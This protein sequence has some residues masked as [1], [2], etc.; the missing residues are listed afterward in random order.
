M[1]GGL[2][3]Y[4]YAN[5]DPVNFRDPS[6]LSAS[7]GACVENGV[8]LSVFECE[9]AI[10]LLGSEGWLCEPWP[11]CA[12]G[13]VKEPLF[14]PLEILGFGGI[15][16]GIGKASL[17]TLTRD[18]V[19]FGLR[20]SSIGAAARRA[21]I[22][23]DEFVDDVVLGS[24]SVAGGTARFTANVAVEKNSLFLRGL[25]IEGDGTLRELTDFAR[26]WARELGLGEAVLVGATRTTGARPGH[27]PR[28]LRLPVR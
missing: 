11:K 21:G 19:R 12:S 3:L 20:R 15:L 16:R 2:N 4:G 23:I 1:Q 8:A 9:A 27:I 22:S 24:V 25:H 10:D 18:A 7:D 5:G 13:A 26:S 14:G 17:R 6:G 28:I